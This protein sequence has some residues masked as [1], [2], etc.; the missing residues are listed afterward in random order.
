MN[1]S[2]GEKV[3]LVLGLTGAL[4]GVVI[5]LW[6]AVTDFMATGG[7][8]IGGIIALVAG[9][10]IVGTV[11]LGLLDPLLKNAILQKRGQPAE[12]TILKVWDTGVTINK[13]PQVGLLLEIRPPGQLPYQAKTKATVSRLYPHLCQ[14]GM[15]AQ[16]LYDPQNPK[17]VM[18]KTI[19]L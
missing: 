17:R 5:S 19:G 6:V 7:L 9:V 18:V 8:T 4:V 13:D 11:W 14:P 15:K 2:P 16:V 1:L 12:A 10:I 3:G